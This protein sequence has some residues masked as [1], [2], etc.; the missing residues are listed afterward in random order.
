MT[1]QEYRESLKSRLFLD[2]LNKTFP[3][4]SP[5][6]RQGKVQ[7]HLTRQRRIRIHQQTLQ[8]L[9]EIQ[10]LDNPNSGQSP[11]RQPL[12]RRYRYPQPATASKMI[13]PKV[14]DV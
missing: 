3:D 9:R 2:W 11:Q 7:A 1:F 13:I 12:Y 6:E 4:L 8:S 10:Q 5:E 14:T